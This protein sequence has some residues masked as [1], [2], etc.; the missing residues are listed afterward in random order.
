MAPPALGTVARD[1]PVR[2]LIL[3]AL[4][5][6]RSDHFSDYFDLFCDDAVWMMPN[7][8][9]DIGLEEARSFYRFTE[10]FRF[11][12]QA[13]VEEL[14]VDG[15]WAFARI[16]FDG[17]LRPKHDDAPPLRSVS[18]HIWILRREASGW[19]IA[20]DIWNTPRD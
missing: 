11:D 9:R 17:Y 10:K 5:I 15:G 12:Q 14:V 8:K 4:R 7:S 18:R 6:I 19:K 3:E 1:D 20:R 13:D 2:L 16:T